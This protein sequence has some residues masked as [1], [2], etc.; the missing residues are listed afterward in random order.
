MCQ[1][2]AV[3]AVGSGVVEMSTRLWWAQGR[4]VEWR[5]VERYEEER[6][7]SNDRRPPPEG[8]EEEGWRMEVNW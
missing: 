8:G 6:V 2:R 4:R 7:D 5:E 1:N 3:S